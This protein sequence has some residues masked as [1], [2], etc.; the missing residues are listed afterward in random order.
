LANQTTSCIQHLMN[1]M[2]NPFDEAR[3]IAKQA[4]LAVG[5]EPL[6]WVVK[7]AL[8]SIKRANRPVTK[9]NVLYVINCLEEA[10]T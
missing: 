6:Q 3:K 9:A 8:D 10:Y 2:P 5:N 4:C 7:E 1:M